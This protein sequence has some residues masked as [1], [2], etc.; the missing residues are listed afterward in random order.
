[1]LLHLNRPVL[2]VLLYPDSQ[3]NRM[4]SEIIQM[5]QNLR[6]WRTYVA[7]NDR[8]ILANYIAGGNNFTTV[9]YVLGLSITCENAK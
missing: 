5:F 1:M 9:E 7:T 8:P 2:E 4:H 3:S 6:L